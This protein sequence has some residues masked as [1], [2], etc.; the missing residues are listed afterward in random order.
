MQPTARVLKLLLSIS[1]PRQ[2]LAKHFGLYKAEV[3]YRLG[4][5]HNSEHVEFET[6][7]WVDWFNNRQLLEPIGHI[8]PAEASG[9][10]GH[11]GR[12]QLTEA[13]EN[14]GRFTR[15][16]SGYVGLHDGRR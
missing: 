9:S 1:I 2:I 11:G 8:P 14:P 3:I 16:L 13:P 12:T 7:E 6:L 10:H 15:S 4:S 5:W